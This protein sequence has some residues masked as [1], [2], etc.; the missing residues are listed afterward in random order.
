MSAP[1]H[2]R[3]S[4]VAYV[5]AQL[6]AEELSGQGVSVD[7][8]DW[9]PPAGAGEGLEYLATLA[10]RIAK[11]NDAAVDR[12]QEAHPVVTGVGQAIDVIPDIDSKTFLH[13][14]PPIDWSHSQAHFAGRSSAP[15][16]TRVSR[17]TPR[18]QS[19]SPVRT[20]FTSLPATSIRPWVRW[21]A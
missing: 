2:G 1:L 20:R 7:V 15:R 16:S 5:G 14:G 6:F 17:P 21:L 19:A 13:A 3:G 4:A 12:M 11:A 9:Q 18:T 8:I 10:A